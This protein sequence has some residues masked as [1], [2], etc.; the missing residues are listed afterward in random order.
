MRRQLAGHIATYLANLPVQAVTYGFQ[1]EHAAR[2]HAV[3]AFEA[4]RQAQIQQL[5]HR[6]VLDRIARQALEQLEELLPA[7]GLVVEVAQQAHLRPFAL[8]APGRGHHRLV[9]HRAEHITGCH[10]LAAFTAIV[11]RPVFE[12][13]DRAGQSCVQRLEILALGAVLEAHHFRK[14]GR[15]RGHQRVETD[16]EDFRRAQASGVDHPLLQLFEFRWHGK[17]RQW[18]LR[19]LFAAAVD[20]YRLVILPVVHFSDHVVNP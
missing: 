18:A 8:V 4:K 15:G 10:H 11:Q 20:D 14:Q 5:Q 16:V 3:F 12:Q 2:Q 17:I 1:L 13:L 6:Q 7:K 19:G 9:E